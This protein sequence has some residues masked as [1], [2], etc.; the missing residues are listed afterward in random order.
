MLIDKF[1]RSCVNLGTITKER[2]ITC[3]KKRVRKL[4]DKEGLFTTEGVAAYLETHP[5]LIQR[6]ST[7]ERVTSKTKKEHISNHCKARKSIIR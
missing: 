6:I 3:K 7:D 2:I 4:R 5:Q 1:V